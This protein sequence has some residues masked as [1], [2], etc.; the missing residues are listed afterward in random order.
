[1]NLGDRMK[2]YENVNR[3]YLMEKLPVI[4]RI[5]GK[6][7][8]TFTRGMEKPYDRILQET[9]AGTMK[10]LCENIQGAVFGYTQSDE[11][12]VVLYTSNPEGS[13][14][15]DGNIQKIVS[16]SASMATLQFNKLLKELD[17]EKRYEQKYDMA[18]FDSRVFNVPSE[19]E[20]RN[21]L[22]W[23]QEDAVKNSIQMLAQFHFSHKSLQGLNGSQLQEK[24]FSEKSVNW[25]DVETRFKRGVACKK[26]LVEIET[27]NGKAQRGK[28]IVD[29]EIP[30][31]TAQKDYF[32]I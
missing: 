17:T 9:M 23:R 25:N 15:F 31:I 21:C 26:H 2:Q 7:F 6:A 11:I 29:D 16:V 30:Q 14:W 1:M 19:D 18:M 5:D 27:E 4:I 3:I 28:W 10:Y 32:I 20:A 8:H 22:I 12:T 13:I 24:L